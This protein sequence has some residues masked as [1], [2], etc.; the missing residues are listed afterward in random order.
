MH[1]SEN[2]K[3]YT[4]KVCIAVLVVALC[5][6]FVACGDDEKKSADVGN[7]ASAETVQ[8]VLPDD[9]I[10]ITVTDPNGNDDGS[11]S[12]N[13]DSDVA[14]SAVP[15]IPGDIT[16]P[17]KDDEKITSGTSASDKGESVTNKDKAT[18]GTKESS[19]SKV[20]EPTLPPIFATLPEGGLELPDD[21][22]E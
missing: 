6:A 15:E 16:I 8:T 3:R 20:T 13:G 17:G 14:G 7:N 18:G 4:G 19:T 10:D 21:V 11:V 2:K 1:R 22:W 12:V 9:E 5:T